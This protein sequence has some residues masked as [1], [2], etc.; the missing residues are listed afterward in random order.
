MKNKSFPRAIGIVG[1]AGP[2]ASAFL[3][4]TII[5][6]CQKIYGANDYNEFPEI[7]LESYPFVRGDRKK[8]QEDISL[9]FSKLKN[10]GAALFSLASNSFH[11]YLPDVTTLAFVNLIIESLKEASHCNISKA[12]IL[13]ARP[14][15]E[16]KLYEQTGL[17][18]VYPREED[19]KRIE[20]MIREVAGGIVTNDQATKLDGI[21]KYFQ[22][23]SLVDGV[24]IAC[25][26]LPLIH[27]KF[28]LVG[29]SIIDSVEVLAKRL[30]ALSRS[31]GI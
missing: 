2:M 28:P 26:E 27:R 23:Q 21:I 1:G 12:L 4:T 3:Y 6:L 18:C 15:I 19:Q 8:I 22:R 30:L 7:I 29:I 16:L 13:A 10:A 14:T 17:Q 5:E 11:G 9:C 31:E 24:I 25:T 20:K